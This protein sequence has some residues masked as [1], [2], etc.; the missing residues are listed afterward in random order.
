MKADL[1]GDPLRRGGYEWLCLPAEFEP[2]RR[3]STSIGWADP[4][5]EFGQ[6]LWPEK[7][8]QADLESLKS[9]LGSYRYTRASISSG[10]RQ[11]AAVC[12]RSTG[13]ATGSRGEPIR[14]RQ[15]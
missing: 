4:R 11:R 6:L 15:Q 10:R 13:G 5:T 3:C 8:T 9:T 1:T 12:S 2:D 7:V 14:R